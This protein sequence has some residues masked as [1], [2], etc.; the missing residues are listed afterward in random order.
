MPWNSN[1]PTSVDDGQL[2]DEDVFNPMLENLV[3]LRFATVLLGATVRVNP[4]TATSGTTEKV[5][6]TSNTFPLDPNTTYRVRVGLRYLNSNTGD[7]YSIR[8]REDSL[9]GAEA[10][11]V[12][13]PV[14]TVI[15]GYWKVVEYVHINGGTAINKPWVGTLQRFSGSGTIQALEKTFISVE[16][17]SANTVIT[18]V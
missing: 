13:L 15:A 1:M 11:H 10:L 7:R 3:F 9:T 12:E 16:R 5:F 2:I 14:N 4:D 8:I 18:T 6:V 17:L